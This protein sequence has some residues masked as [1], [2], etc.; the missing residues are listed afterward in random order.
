MKGIEDKELFIKTVKDVMTPVLYVLGY[1]ALTVVLSL[2]W[3]PMIVVMGIVGGG[4]IVATMIYKDRLA[5]KK[6]EEERNHRRY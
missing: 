6:R 2:L 4:L 3:A 1:I 5:A